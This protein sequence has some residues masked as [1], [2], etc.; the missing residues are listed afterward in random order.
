MALTLTMTTPAFYDKAEPM[1]HGRSQR[2]PDHELPNRS[3]I[4][5]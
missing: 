3:V 5:L 2:K 4:I 1:Q